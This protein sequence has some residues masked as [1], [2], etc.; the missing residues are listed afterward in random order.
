[1]GVESGVGGGVVDVAGK[2]LTAVDAGVNVEGVVDSQTEAS[3]AVINVTA[4]SNE[5]AISMWI[6]RNKGKRFA[7]VIQSK[8]IAGNWVLIKN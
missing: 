1:M 6:V 3:I 5:S 4:V 2:H 7:F 8:L